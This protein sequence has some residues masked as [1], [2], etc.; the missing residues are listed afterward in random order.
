M[1]LQETILALDCIRPCDT[2]RD[3]DDATFYALLIDKLS[4]L[5]AT[6]IGS[7][8]GAD[9]TT[10]MNSAICEVADAHV[11]QQ[12]NPQVLKAILLHLALA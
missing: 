9:L 12:A 7:I 4:D 6:P 11:F 2:L 10:A 8:T 1:A 3:I 5:T